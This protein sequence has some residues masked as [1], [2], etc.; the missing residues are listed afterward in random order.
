VVAGSGC[1]LDS[2]LSLKP[3]AKISHRKLN[4]LQGTIGFD[5]IVDGGS[6]KPRSPVGLVKQPGKHINAD[7]HEYALA[8]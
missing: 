1:S 4:H 2:M 7:S 8:A 5:V 3:E 6:C